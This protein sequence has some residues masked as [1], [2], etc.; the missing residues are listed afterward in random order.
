MWTLLP[1]VTMVRRDLRLV[2]LGRESLLDVPD[3][4]VVGE[5][6]DPASTEVRDE[7]PDGAQVGH[8]EQDHLELR[9]RTA[10]QDGVGDPLPLVRVADRHD[11][12]GPGAGEVLG[13]QRAEA[14]GGAGHDRRPARL[15]SDVG[16]GEAKR[17]GHGWL[18]VEVEQ[19]P[20]G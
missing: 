13:E 10:R 2:P 18:L 17:V 15:V 5:Q 11:H 1:V 8:V 4:G 12:L 6:I 16:W 9:L 20:V 14:A 19:V 3:P 7:A